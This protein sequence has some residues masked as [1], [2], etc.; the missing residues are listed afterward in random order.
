MDAAD[1]I[2]GYRPKRLLGREFN[3]TARVIRRLNCC[4]IGN[5]TAAASCCLIATGVAKAL[6]LPRTKTREVVHENSFD[7]AHH[8]LKLRILDT[9]N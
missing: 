9:V 6:P 7:F 8:F 3:R 1:A 4:W 2:G 5:C